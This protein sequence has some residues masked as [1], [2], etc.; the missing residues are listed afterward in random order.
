VKGR[1]PDI[2]PGQRKAKATEAPT[3]P[4][5]LSD[6]ARTEWDRVIALVAGAGAIAKP[7]AD[8]LAAYCETLVIFRAATQELRRD[9]ITYEADGGL[10]KRH[11]STSI[12]AE[13]RKDLI[14]Y[15]AELGLTPISRQRLK[16]EPAEDDPLGDFLAGKGGNG[17]R[18]AE[19]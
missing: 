7:D 16:V 18:I 19:G 4:A 15:A 3:A 14:R 8:V 17:M 11:P 9:G 5:W 13:A 2:R 10:V 12:A 6:N 1:K